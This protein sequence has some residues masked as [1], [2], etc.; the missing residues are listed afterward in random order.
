MLVLIDLLRH[1]VLLAIDLR[2]LLVGQFAAIGRAIIFDLIVDPALAAL[3]VLRFS[4]GQLAA[5]NALRYASLLIHFTLAD[6]RRWSLPHVGI[7]LVS[8]DLLREPVLLFC[9]LF[10][11]V[12]VQLAAVLLLHLI[13]FAIETGFFSLQVGGF[14]GGELAALYAVGDELLLV[15]FAL[16]NGLAIYFR[17]VG[18][19]RV[20]SHN[21]Q[22]QGREGR[23]EK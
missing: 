1:L 18:I 8:G 12:V 23:S 14:T 9:K 16:L 15:M 2:T 22:S 7:V 13:L 4:G 20:L 11:V 17:G 21:W 10:L 5:G 19:G 6:F 3:Q